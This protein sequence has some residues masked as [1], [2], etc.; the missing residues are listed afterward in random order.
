M[1]TLYLIATPIGNLEDLGLRALR[2]LKEVDLIACEDTR[3]TRK[4]LHHYGIDTPRQS[5]HEH[6]EARRTTEFIQML[7][8]GRRIALVTDAGMPLISD[9]GHMLVSACRCEGIPVVPIPGPSAAL[10]ALAGSGLPAERFLFAGFLSARSS[11][12]RR[13]LQELGASPWT[14]I[15]YEAPHRILSALEDMRAILGDREACLAR[16]LTKIHE[17]WI[18]GSLSEI[19]GI[20]G[21]RAGIRGEI[22]VVI[23]P[24]PTPT[25]PI[26]QEGNLQQELEEEIRKTGT[27]RNEALRAVARRRGLSR[28]E[29]YK[30]MVEEN[31]RLT[32]D[33]E[34]KRTAEDS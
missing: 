15:F 9:P 5:Y 22:T 12:R 10:A 26:R 18:R 7:K 27:T 11:L 6:N 32:R 21:S 13:Q 28:R 34:G 30:L 8:E 25:T 16:E 24:A 23:A 1:G 2:L 17:E 29:A 31:S 14:L 33:A 3:H 19:L 20:L 4:L